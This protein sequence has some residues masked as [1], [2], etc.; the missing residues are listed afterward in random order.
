MD[1]NATTSGLDEL[2][3]DGADLQTTVIDFG[4][5]VVERVKMSDL[6][7]LTVA[8]M[9]SRALGKEL[10]RICLQC[11]TNLGL[12]FTNVKVNPGL[13]KKFDSSIVGVLKN[14]RDCF[15]SRGKQLLLC[16]PPS[17]LVDLL[18]LTGVYDGYQIVEKTSRAILPTDLK[19]EEETRPDKKAP[20]GA[21]HGGIGGGIVQKRILQLNQS[22]KRTVTLEKGLESAERCVKRFLPQT[23]PTATG[24]GFAFSYNSSEKVG[25]DF[26]DFIPLSE[27]K[28]GL[29]IGDVSGH[30]IDAAILMGITKKVINL[31]AKGPPDVTP[32]QVLSQANADLLGDFTK[33]NFV[34]ALYGILD[35]P[36]GLFTF[37]RAGHEVPVLF[38]PGREPALVESK[39]IPMGIDAGRHFNSIL[40]EKTVL[41]P[42]GACLLLFTDGLSECWSS[43][44]EAYGRKR[45]LFS[46]GQIKSAMSCE[47]VLSSL[48][49]TLRDFAGGRAQEDDMTAVLVQRQE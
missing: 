24:Y 38:G 8:G 33:Y 44:G 32:T 15:R 11:S 17:E 35:L 5:A 22:L 31:R 16:M 4:D 3:K 36:T 42:A 29:L 43:R 30:G 28:L 39:G 25:G 46:L 6:S 41:L 47:R 2:I 7:I 37:A 19:P 14:I 34:T 26:F 13:R 23:P 48:L 21:Q 27:S 1:S 45:L 49:E 40:E 9:Y 12:D 18:K 10:E 20:S